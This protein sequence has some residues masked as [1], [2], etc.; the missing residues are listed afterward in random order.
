MPG[1]EVCTGLR[2]SVPVSMKS[3]R[4][5]VTEPS[6]WRKIQASGARSRIAPLRAA[7]AGLMCWRYI[8][9]DTI[10]LP[11]VPRSSAVSTICT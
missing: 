9:G 3:S 7:S 10:R 8:L 4:S 11:E 2:M 1:N 5:G 6:Q